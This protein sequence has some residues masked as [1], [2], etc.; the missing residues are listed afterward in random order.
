M[1]VDCRFAENHP[2]RPVGDRT[3]RV[4]KIAK[5]C[6]CFSAGSSARG[7]VPSLPG[8]WWR[9]GL[10]AER[11]LQIVGTTVLSLFPLLPKLSLSGVP[12]VISVS[13]LISYFLCSFRRSRRQSG[14]L[15]HLINTARLKALS[16][17]GR[18]SFCEPAWVCPKPIL[19]DIGAN[20]RGSSVL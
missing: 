7:V 6:G 9:K 1:R 10:V 19:E 13:Y 11:A 16:S 17:R 3:R 20:Q 12:V 15:A 5:S 14:A 18:A 8:P 4:C 2:R